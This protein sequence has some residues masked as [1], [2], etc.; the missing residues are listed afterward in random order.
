M[1]EVKL[2]KIVVGIYE[3]SFENSTWMERGQKF[4]V[5]L[6]KKILGNI[7]F[8]E[9][10]IHRKQSLGTPDNWSEIQQTIA[11]VNR[12]IQESFSRDFFPGF[13]IAFYHLH[14]YIRTFLLFFFYNKKQITSLVENQPI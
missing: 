13:P 11:V 4:L 9:Q 12:S 10:I 5:V 2:Q 6:K 1:W 8:F 3:I 7:C 14:V